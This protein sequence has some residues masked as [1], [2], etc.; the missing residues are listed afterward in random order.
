[1]FHEEE[2]TSDTFV[3]PQGYTERFGEKQMNGNITFFV[4]MK[5]P[6]GKFL[7][8]G[9]LSYQFSLRTVIGSDKFKTAISS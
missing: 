4:Y 1:M 7:L 5:T 3:R 8:R 2:N 9:T 6:Q